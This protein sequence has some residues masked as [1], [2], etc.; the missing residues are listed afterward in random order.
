MPGGEREKKGEQSKKIGKSMKK[1]PSNISQYINIS[2]KG[3]QSRD[4]FKFIEPFKKLRK[5]APFL[6]GPIT[7]VEVV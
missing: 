4:F 1:N 5:T 3:S 7:F 2:M 6:E